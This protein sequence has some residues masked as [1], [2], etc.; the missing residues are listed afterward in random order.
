M[1]YAA[2]DIHKHAFE[3]AVLDPESGEVVEQRSS[4]DRESL[5]RWAER[6]RGPRRGGGDR[7]DDRLAL[8]VTRAGRR[9][10]GY[11]NSVSPA[12]RRFI[13]PARIYAP[14]A[15]RALAPVPPPTVSGRTLPPVE[16]NRART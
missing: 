1:L 14:H 13:A 5:T 6:W 8:D 4:A 3:L 9:R 12:N 15:P 2:I 10:Q 16:P 7:G 11:V